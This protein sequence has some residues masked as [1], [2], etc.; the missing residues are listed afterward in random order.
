MSALET[1]YSMSTGKNLSFSEQELVD[2]AYSYYGI[3]NDGCRGA[4]SNLAFNYVLK[5][6]ISLS[7]DY[8]YT[9]GSSG[10]VFSFF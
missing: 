3:D 7:S 8:P 9:S 10:K 5:Y 1:Y 2:C 4:P 6:G